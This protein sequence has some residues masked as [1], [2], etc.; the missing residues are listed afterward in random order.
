MKCPICGKELEIKKRQVGTAENG[1]PVFNEYAV[2]RDCR[3]QW[4]LDK[5]RAKKAAAKH[6]AAPEAPKEKEAPAPAKQ[7]EAPV[8]K[9]PE[10]K[11][12]AKKPVPGNG[13]PAKKPAPGDGA[14][15][16]KPTPK[17][18]AP[19]KKPAPKD[20]V[21]AKKP[22]PGDGAPAKKPAPGDGVPAKK[23]APGNGAPAKKPTPGDGAPVRKRT[24]GEDREAAASAKKPV[25]KH[26][27]EGGAEAA[28]AKKPVRKRH[29]EGA[30]PEE[31]KRYSNLPPEKVR[32]KR[33]NA[34]RK[35]YEE[36]LATGTIGK[37]P[38]KRK[39]AAEENETGEIRRKSSGKGTPER[40]STPVKSASR[41][42]EPEPDIYEDDYYDD[43][44]RFRPMRIL[45]GILSLA[46]F[47]YFIY[48]GF[49]TGLADTSEGGSIS[50]GTTFIVLALCMLVSA[51]L[52]FI[53]QKKNT[54]FAFLLPMLFYLGSAVFAFLQRGDSLELLIAAVAGAVLAVISLILAITS[55]GGYE[56]ENDYDEAFEDDYA[57]E[58][59][60]D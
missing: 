43:E 36:M 21:P 15:A 19:A 58:E 18:G 6:A 11:A 33:G 27:P 30:R 25:R 4:N 53:M 20:G 24:P 13:A 32:T 31:E 26:R 5:Q 59:F 22:A 49:V 39:K 40:R 16:K 28:P 17:D 45:L 29:P 3:K 48:K 7:Q 41:K 23:P 51:L 10:Q 12:P 42:Y 1:E 9:A 60:E 14:P 57:D 52:Y 46:A 44:P 35:S 37:T 47:G 38:V 50:S 34:A 55:R 2:C 54:V 8:K 56:E